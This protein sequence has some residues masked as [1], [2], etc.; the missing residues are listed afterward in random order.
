MEK[1]G[2]LP[3]AFWLEHIEQWRASGLSQSAYCQQHELVLHKFGYWKRKLSATE[4]MTTNEASS[5]FV[6]VQV[7][8]LLEKDTGLSL[9][10]TDG[11]RLDG[12]N[13]NNIAMV[14]QL[15]EVLR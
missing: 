4:V 15:L 9:Q 3:Q 13:Q 7:A 8:P 12:I 2:K 11:T 6:R 5:G 10:F 1:V 14:S